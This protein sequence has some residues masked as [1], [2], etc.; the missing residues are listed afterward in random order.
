MANTE[1]V[2][3]QLGFPNPKTTSRTVG[4]G[5]PMGGVRGGAPRPD[6]VH[7]YIYIGFGV[8]NSCLSCRLT[9]SEGAGLVVG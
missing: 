3:V 5:E 2:D 7:I 4:W 9:A 6:H 1:G 8:Q